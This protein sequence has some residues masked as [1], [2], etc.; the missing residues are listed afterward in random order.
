[1]WGRQKN[2]DTRGRLGAFLDA[3]SEIE[4][5]YACSGTVMLDGR[6]RGEIA[7]KDTLL[8]GEHGVVHARVTVAILVVRGEVVGD[9]TASE[10]VELKKT[11]RVTG[12]IEAPVIVMEEGAIHDGGCRMTVDAEDHSHPAVVALKA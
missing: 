11:A 6:F 10:R 5:K 9:V 7:A 12:D 1:M 3:G 4:G 8:V 2:A